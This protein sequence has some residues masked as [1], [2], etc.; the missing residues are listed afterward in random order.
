[1]GVMIRH[2][3]AV[4]AAS[5]VLLAFANY[6]RQNGQRILISLQITFES[7][8]AGDKVLLRHVFQICESGCR[9]DIRLRGVGSRGSIMGPP[10][11]LISLPRS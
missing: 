11:D 1:M 10:N 2:R 8:L 6:G 5:L 4:L 9:Q 7:V 3:S